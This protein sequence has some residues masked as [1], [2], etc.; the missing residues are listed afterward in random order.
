MYV[1]LEDLTTINLHQKELKNRVRRDHLH[2]GDA[3]VVRIVARASN[4]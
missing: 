4:V 1:C 2:V 3:L